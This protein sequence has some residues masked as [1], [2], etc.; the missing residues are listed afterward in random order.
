VRIPVEMTLSPQ[1]VPETTINLNVYILDN[2][3]KIDT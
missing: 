2:D 1:A 3:S